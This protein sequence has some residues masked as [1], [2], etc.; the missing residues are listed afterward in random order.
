MIFQQMATPTHPISVVVAGC[1][2]T[3]SHVLSGLAQLNKMRLQL[4]LMPLFVTAYDPD[5]VTERNIG[6][7]L[8]SPADINRNKAVLLIERINRFYGFNWFAIPEKLIQAPKS[9]NILIS[10]VDT[11]ND[12]KHM[13]AAIK[14]TSYSYEETNYYWMDIGNDKSSGQIIMGTPKA[15]KEN[16]KNYLPHF[17]DEYPDLI[18]KNTDYSCDQ[19]FNPYNQQSLFINKM[20]ANYGCLMLTNLLQ[21]YYLDYRG[22]YINISSLAIKKIPV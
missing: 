9:M 7:Q 11:I 15:K 2:G 3:G 8:F 5:I 21:D 13:L 19:E 20:M 4:K 10:C 18:D 6:R 17:F 16:K 22:L 12:R 1:G 14:S